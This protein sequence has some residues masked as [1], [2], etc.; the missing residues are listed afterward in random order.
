MQIVTKYDKL[1]LATRSKVE[2]SA[3]KNK[4][5]TERYTTM[6]TIS[7]TSATASAAILAIANN[8]NM[9]APERALLI[10]GMLEGHTFKA[11][12]MKAKPELD[13][14]GNPIPREAVG[15]LNWRELEER[16][17]AY[18]AWLEEQDWKAS[19]GLTSN[20][21]QPHEYGNL[22]YW[23]LEKDSFRN[24]KVENLISIELVD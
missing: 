24:F 16:S 10:K 22:Q 23:D 11:S 1:P 14:Q 12:Y 20:R 21:K 5:Q 17:A 15:S 18:R 4:Q 3:H 19:K 2:R 9:S 6:N 7:I 8:V 13:E